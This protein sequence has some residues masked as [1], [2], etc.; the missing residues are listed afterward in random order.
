LDPSEGR[1]ELLN[2]LPADIVKQLVALIYAVPPQAYFVVDSSM[3]GKISPISFLGNWDFT[4]VYL[5]QNIR[6]KSKVQIIDYLVRLGITRQRAEQLYQE[7]LWVSKENTADWISKRLAFYT[8]SRGKAK[9]GMVLFDNGFIYNIQEQTVYSYFPAEGKYKIPKSLFIKKN[10]KLSEVVY[11][12]SDLDSSALVLEDHGKF[13][14]ILLPKELVNS[15]FVRLYF[16]GGE[17]LKYF[18][19]FTDEQDEAERIA[20]FEINWDSLSSFK[21]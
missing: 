8:I 19:L 12:D 17:G 15:L 4:K 20:V 10:D 13:L 1:Q 18:K 6:K 5:A 11:P 2:F 14:F 16:L 21:D 9:N 3:L 7:L